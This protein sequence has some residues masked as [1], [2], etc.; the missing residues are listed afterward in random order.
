MA[1]FFHCGGW[2]SQPDNQRWT[3]GPVPEPS[4][5]VASMAVAH[6]LP[7]NTTTGVPEPIETTTGAPEPGAPLRI[8]SRREWKAATH[9]SWI[10]Q[11][12]DLPGG[13]TSN[14]G[15]LWT[16]DCYGGDNQHW[17][18]QDGQLKYA[19]N[20]SKCVDLL[21]GD[22]H[23]GNLVGLWDCN[24]G[25]NQQWEYDSNTRSIYRGIGVRQKCLQLGSDPTQDW[26]VAAGTQLNIWDC[27]GGRTE[28]WSQQWYVEDDPHQSSLAV[29]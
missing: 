19:A 2:D 10:S 23:N 5:P 9:A 1:G 6:S 20:T 18:F 16:W 11:C 24:N 25:H 4:E 28:G 21:G 15:V 14:G 8:R 26:Y 12:M 13:D 17:F 7:A 29:V 27:D 3:V 22:D